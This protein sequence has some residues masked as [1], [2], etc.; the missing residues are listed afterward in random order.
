M[1]LILS[2]SAE[3]ERNNAELRLKLATLETVTA[4]LKN[5]LIHSFQRKDAARS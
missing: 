1:F 3:Y 5:G 4:N 2:R